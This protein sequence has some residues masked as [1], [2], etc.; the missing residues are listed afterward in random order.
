MKLR[1]GGSKIVFYSNSTTVGKFVN[2]AVADLSVGETIMATGKA[3][4]DGS[5][6]ASSIQIRPATPPQAQPNPPANTNQ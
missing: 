1:E 5:I 4:S 3:N 2:G 6:N